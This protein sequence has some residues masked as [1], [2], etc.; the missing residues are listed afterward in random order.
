MEDLTTTARIRDAAIAR[1][2]EHGLAGTTIRAVATD[3]G[4]SPGLVMHHFGSKEGLHRACD[5]YVVHRVMEVKRAALESRSY[6]QPAAM[7]DLYRL[8][9]P[10]LRYLGWTLGTGNDTAARIFDEFLDDT[11]RLLV[12]GQETGIIG[13]IHGDPRKQ[14]ALLVAI[15]LA[16]LVFHDHLSRVLGADVLT[17]EGIIAASPYALQIFSGDLFDRDAIDQAREALE[18]LGQDREGTA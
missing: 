12:E 1:F 9:T 18:G 5:E 15:R 6:R 11:E 8:A 14:A 7:A 17:E 2:P 16:T 4:V 10:L 13:E 3:A